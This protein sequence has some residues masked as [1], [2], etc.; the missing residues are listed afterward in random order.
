M[1]IKP[2]RCVRWLVLVACLAFGASAHAKDVGEIALVED[3]DG[4]I[5]AAGGSFL[6]QEVI[7]KASCAF[8]Q[9][10]A[11]KYGLHVF[12]FTFP[13]GLFGGTPTGWPVTVPAKGIGL[14]GWGDHGAAF[15]APGGTLR[16]AIKMGELDA[17]PDDPD[18]L[19]TLT[20]AGLS[21]IEV[22]GHELGHQWMAAVNFK[23]A[24]GQLHCLH[25][26]FKS[27]NTSGRNAQC[28]G[29]AMSDFATH[30][31]AFFAGGSVMYGNSIDDLGNGRFRL[32]NNG[33]KYSAFD[34]YLMGLRDKREVP[35]M[36]VI[37]PSDLA[38]SGSGDYPQPPGA[39]KIVSG[40]RIDFTVDDVIR[41]HGPRDPAVEPCHWKAAFAIVH[42]KDAPPSAAQIAKVDAYRKRFEA[43]YATAT[44]QRGSIDTTLAATGA[45]TTGCPAS[46]IRP[47]GGAAQDA[48]TPGDGGL[49]GEPASDAGNDANPP[50][51]CSCRS[52]D[53]EP[54]AGATWICFALLALALLAARRGTTCRRLPRRS[55]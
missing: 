6:P 30:W 50:G 11:D 37:A 20:A 49:G 15:C 54:A 10:H 22:L 1:S 21:A 17:L 24:D 18:A 25:R 48:A 9:S 40:T 46:G 28:D 32:Y 7:A 16:H 45:G 19:Y 34:Q 43:F 53:G 13:L 29:Y 35:A 47:D 36:F 2:S 8:L 33:P 42:P 31:S 27:G 52:A 5:A 55:K 12:F 51:G 38:N 41:V 44:D 4:S 3:V 14:D 39:E 26:Q 23:L